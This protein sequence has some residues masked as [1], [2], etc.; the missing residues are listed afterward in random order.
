MHLLDRAFTIAVAKRTDEAGL[1]RIRRKQLTGVAGI[2]AERIA[3]ALDLPAT[4]AG[5][6]RL[7]TLHPLL[8]P[9]AYVHAAVGAASLEVRRGPADEDGAWITLCDAGEIAPLQAIVRAL[10]PHFDVE[11][12]PLADGTEGWSLRV[13]R[14]D[15]PAKE[16]DA[17]AVTRFSTGAAFEFEPRASLPVVGV[18]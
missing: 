8:N 18:S 5:A 9:A 2:A 3:R 14:R 17:V 10:D 1:L 13:V 4:E 16:D 15:E 6:L 7:L 11:V 12:D